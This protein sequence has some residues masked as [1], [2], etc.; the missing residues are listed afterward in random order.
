LHLEL[1]QLFNNQLIWFSNQVLG[2]L[3][4]YIKPIETFFFFNQASFVIINSALK[5]KAIVGSKRE[6]A[7]NIFLQIHFLRG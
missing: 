5:E 3:L 1:A 2:H 7:K 6:L 4:Q